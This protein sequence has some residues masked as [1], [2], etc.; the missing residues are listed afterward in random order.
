[1]GRISSKVHLAT[2]EFPL[3]VSYY[4]PSV[5]RQT[6]HYIQSSERLQ[7]TLMYRGQVEVQVKG[8]VYVLGAGDIHVIRPHELFTFRTAL[9]DTRYVHLAISQQLIS[10]PRGHF[11]QERFVRPLWDGELDIPGLFRTGDEG[12]DDLYRELS[13]VEAERENTPEYAAQMFAVVMAVCSRIMSCC[14]PVR[15]E[16]K[17]MNTTENIVRCCVEYINENFH[18]KLTLGEIAGQVHLHPNYLCAV[19]KKC[20]GISVLEHLTRRRFQRAT[21]LLR[22][23]SLPV[24]QVAEKCGFQSAAFFALKFRQRYDCTPTEYRRRFVT[25]TVSVD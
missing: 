17:S 9:A 13:R 4:T 22:G 2:P 19:F 11:F 16:E 6:P 12:Y 20:T 25:P 14:V 5:I 15:P 23:T 10:L 3:S 1:M 7:I 8:K 21:Q 24:N 18:R